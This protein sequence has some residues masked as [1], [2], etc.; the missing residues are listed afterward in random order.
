[1]NRMVF[2]KDKWNNETIETCLLGPSEKNKANREINYF[3]NCICL[4]VG[5]HIIVF[6]PF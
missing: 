2:S 4:P 5:A 6:F 1:M 3:S